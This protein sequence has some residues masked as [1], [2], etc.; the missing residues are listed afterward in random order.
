[1]LK[2]KINQKA[3]LKAAQGR[4]MFEKEALSKG[5]VKANLDGKLEPILPYKTL[6]APGLEEDYYMNL[7]DWSS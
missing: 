6:E 7:L 3:K 2:F 4:K 1:M 5:N